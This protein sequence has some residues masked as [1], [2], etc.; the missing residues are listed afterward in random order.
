MRAKLI[1]R[2]TTGRGYPYFEGETRHTFICCSGDKEV[3]VMVKDY[4]GNSFQELD[5]DADI[6]V[7]ITF[8]IKP[9]PP[10]DRVIKFS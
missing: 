6:E 3:E 2:S 9:K 4:N 10:T 5:T 7:E 8:K 1:S